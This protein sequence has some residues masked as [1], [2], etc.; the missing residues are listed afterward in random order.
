M[1]VLYHTISV[2]FVQLFPPSAVS[3]LQAVRSQMSLVTGHTHINTAEA[4]T[5]RRV[6]ERSRAGSGV[7][8]SELLLLHHMENDG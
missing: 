1:Y 5:L 6:A 4:H 8:R 2:F 7:D 3:H